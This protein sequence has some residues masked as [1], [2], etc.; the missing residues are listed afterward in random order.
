V[1]PPV[2]PPSA[3]V[4][5][6]FPSRQTLPALSPRDRL[7]AFDTAAAG[8]TLS[9]WEQRIDL[10]LSNDGAFAI[11]STTCRLQEHLE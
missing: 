10:K 7:V 8:E 9:H 4:R 11:E 5:G 2:V 3:V 1:K 6:R